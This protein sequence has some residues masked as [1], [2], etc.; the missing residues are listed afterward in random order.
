I[1][2]HMGQTIIT[3]HLG[4][5]EIEILMIL[6]AHG[7]QTVEQIR[8]QIRKYRPIAHTTVVT[9]GKRLAVKGVIHR[10]NTGTH[11]KAA[12]VLH[13][14]VSRTALLATFFEQ[15]HEQLSMSAEERAYTLATLQQGS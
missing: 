12:H 14:V 11:D 8:T 3:P 5:L 6:W 7:P 15:M 4:A 2:S 13:P 1:V 9:T 10:S